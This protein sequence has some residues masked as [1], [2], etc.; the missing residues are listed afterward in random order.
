MATRGSATGSDALLVNISSG[1]IVSVVP[2]IFTSA[3]Q[4]AAAIVQTPEPG[5]GGFSSSA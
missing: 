3:A 2:G 1:M 4:F 5:S